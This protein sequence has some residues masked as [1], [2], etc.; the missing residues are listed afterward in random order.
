MSPTQEGYYEDE[1]VHVAMMVDTIEVSD[2]SPARITENADVTAL[3][4]AVIRD[5]RARCPAS[6]QLPRRRGRIGVLT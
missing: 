5:Q 6:V 3:P 1:H 4:E 2:R